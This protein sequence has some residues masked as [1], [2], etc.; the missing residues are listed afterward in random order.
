[1]SSTIYGPLANAISDA[2][3]T[4]ELPTVSIPTLFQ[5]SVPDWGPRHGFPTPRDS[6]HLETFTP[7]QYQPS[8]VPWAKINNQSTGGIPEACPLNEILNRNLWETYNTLSGK[9]YG[10][11]TPE[12]M[13]DIPSCTQLNGPYMNAIYSNRPWSRVYVKERDEFNGYDTHGKENYGNRSA[14]YMSRY[15]QKHLTR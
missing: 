14:P 8:N 11:Y 6:W 2:S 10:G 4:R 7:P 1:M 12:N 5:Q 3:V 13:K 9:Y 15:L